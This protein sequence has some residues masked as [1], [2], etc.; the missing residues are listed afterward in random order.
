MS[1]TYK[2]IN[3]AIQ[4]LGMLRSSSPVDTTSPLEIPPRHLKIRLSHQPKIHLPVALITSQG[5]FITE[6]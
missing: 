6:T 4:N 5:L 3:D 2:Y 1:S